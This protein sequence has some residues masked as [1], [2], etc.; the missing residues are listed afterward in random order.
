MAS[1]TPAGSEDG[2]D[3]L[4]AL[5]AML[6]Q[7]RTTIAL[8]RMRRKYSAAQARWRLTRVVGTRSSARPIHIF[9]LANGVD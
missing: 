8:N 3:E 5:S 1:E 9:S 2:D 6:E 4:Q 7:Q